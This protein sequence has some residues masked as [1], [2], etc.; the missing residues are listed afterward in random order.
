MLTETSNKALHKETNDNKIA[1][2]F[3]PEE[4]VMSR[5]T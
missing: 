3:T 1:F 2:S 4:Q 5:Q